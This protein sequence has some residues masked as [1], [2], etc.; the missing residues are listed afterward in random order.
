[1][2]ILD[3]R[4]IQAT[5]AEECPESCAALVSEHARHDSRMVIEFGVRE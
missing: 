1:M 5:L 2:F 3:I 4:Q